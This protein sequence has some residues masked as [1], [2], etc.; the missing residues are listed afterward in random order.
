MRP[1]GFLRRTAPQPVLRA[2][3]RVRRLASR[4]V[5]LP[6]AQRRLDELAARV[7]VL[8]RQV[9]ELRRDRDALAALVPEIVRSAGPP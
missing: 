7:D 6:A 1:V 8:E 3:R 4:A 2:G 5:G 9:V